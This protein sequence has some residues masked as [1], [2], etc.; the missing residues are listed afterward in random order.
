MRLWSF[1]SDPIWHGMRIVSFVSASA[2]VILL[3]IFLAGVRGS[4]IP[5]EAAVVTNLGI[6]VALVIR[7]FVLRAKVRHSTSSR[8][9]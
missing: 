6:M 9:T 5:F 3:A 1:W 8:Q 2:T 4:R 7:T